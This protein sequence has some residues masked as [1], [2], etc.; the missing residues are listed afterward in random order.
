MKAPK[1]SAKKRLQF[2]DD[3]LKEAF[4]DTF[5]SKKLGCDVPV[6]RAMKRKFKEFAKD[7]NAMCAKLVDEAMGI[8]LQPKIERE[9]RESGVKSCERKWQ[10]YIK[11]YPEARKEYWGN[12][13]LTRFN[14]VLTETKKK[15]KK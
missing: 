7:M 8:V 9:K 12:M 6:T 13:F 5:H 15:V 2:D 3:K 10:A 14:T 1:S 11:L 4:N